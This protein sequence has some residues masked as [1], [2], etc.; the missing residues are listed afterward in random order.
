[1]KPAGTKGLAADAVCCGHGQ[2]GFS[3]AANDGT[4]MK[5]VYQRKEVMPR[6]ETNQTVPTTCE[7]LL[8]KTTRKDR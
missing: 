1:V 2:A 6:D 4:A 7:A 5:P 3:S 8:D